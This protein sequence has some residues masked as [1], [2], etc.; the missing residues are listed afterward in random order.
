MK[1][2]LTD[3]QKGDSRRVSTLNVFAGIWLIASPW[4]LGLS[5]PPAARGNALLVGIAVLILAAIRL[6]TPHT[7]VLS[8]INVLLGIWLVISPFL[9][10]FY[11]VSS[12][13]GNALVLGGLIGPISL[14][15]A[16]ATRSNAPP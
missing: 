2:N 12:A 9:L 1:D 5:W 16:Y 6:T 3:R 4:V 10:G 13:T 8:W 14:G 7:T 15:A 11:V